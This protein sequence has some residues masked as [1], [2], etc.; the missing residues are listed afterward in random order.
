MDLYLRNSD[1]EII[2]VT[3][4]DEQIEKKSMWYKLELDGNWDIIYIETDKSIQSEIDKKKKVALD[5]FEAA[6]SIINTEYSEDEQKT[7]ELKRTEAEKVLDWWTSIVLEALCIAGETVND[8]ATKIKAKSDAYWTL[9][10]NAEKDYRN[11]LN[12]I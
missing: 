11:E 6:L 4:N 12:N 8:L 2:S 1:S 5:N 9:Y 7:F 3:L 10:C